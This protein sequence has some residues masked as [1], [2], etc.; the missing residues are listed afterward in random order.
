[1]VES[2]PENAG[3][4]AEL[5]SRLRNAA[6]RLLSRRE[7]SRYELEQKLGQVAAKWRVSVDKPKSGYQSGDALA[8][9][10]EVD[11][12]CQAVVIAALLDQFQERD[13]QSDLRFA[14]SL[15]RSRV[16]RGQG[17]DRI[18]Q[19]LRHKGVAEELRAE[20]LEA[21]Q[22]DWFELANN[23]RSRRFGSQPPVDYAQRAKQQR[24]LLYRGFTYEQCNY[25]F[26]AAAEK[27]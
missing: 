8:E 10:S 2:G 16:A 24:F 22:I 7:Y 1:M 9:E 21:A 25:A 27:G 5:R 19:E 11:G 12:E 14:E 18:S 13:Y 3:M 6:F 20:V 15:L 17:S 23:L 26:E 4:V